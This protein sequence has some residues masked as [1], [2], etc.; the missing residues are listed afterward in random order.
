MSADKGFIIETGLNEWSQYFKRKLTPTVIKMY[1]DV[2]LPYSK[3]TI[4]QVFKDRI[5]YGEKF[6]WIHEAT[7]FLMNIE[8]LPKTYDPEGDQTY[9][10]V[11]M[12]RALGY[13]KEFGLKGFGP[14]CDN[15]KYNG[16]D[17]PMPKGERNAV[18]CKWQVAF[19]PKEVIESMINLRNV[20]PGKS[21]EDRREK[22]LREKVRDWRKNEILKN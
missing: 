19:K 20:D 13:L 16:H 8:E 2:F 10:L 7:T 12:E 9:P 18:L 5:K 11:L 15:I 22:Q 6:P 4:R 1:V 14:F 17:C 3:N 21:R